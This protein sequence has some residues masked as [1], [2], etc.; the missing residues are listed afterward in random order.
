MNQL[1][2]KICDENLFPVNEVFKICEKLY[3][4]M[5]YQELKNIVAVSYKLEIQCKKLCIFY[6]I[7]VGALYCLLRTGG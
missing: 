1:K 4:L 6:L 3:L 7:L 2:R 5:K